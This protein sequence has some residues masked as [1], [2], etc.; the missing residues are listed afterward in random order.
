[1]SR[2][3]Q[4]LTL[5]LGLPC[6][7][8]LHALSFRRVPWGLEKGVAVEAL[9]GV[10]LVRHRVFEVLTFSIGPSA[11]TLWLYLV[12][13]S[14]EFLG[15]GWLSVVLPSILA[16][17]VVVALTTVLAARLFPRSPPYLA[18]LLSAGSVWLFHYGQ[19]GLRAISAPVFL[20]LFTLLLD[21]TNVSREP[22]LSALLAGGVLGLSLYAY[23]SCRVLPLA[24]LAY[25]A[26]DG[27]RAQD[28]R[29]FF[30]GIA[31]TVAGAFLVSI[32][33]FLFF[34]REP[35]EFLER[36]YYVFRGGLGPAL[37]NLAGT[38][39]FPF[40]Y[41]D[42]YKVWLGEGHNFDPTSV[43]LVQ[44][45]VRPI[46]PVTA[47]LFAA[48]LLGLG[49]PRSRTL[50]FLLCTFWMGVLPLGLSGPSLTRF[51][52]LQ[53]VYVLLA[54][55]ALGELHE[56]LRRVRPL[57]VGAALVPGALGAWE[58]V[59]EFGRSATAQSEYDAAASSMSA[60]ARDLLDRGERVMLV[61]RRGRDLVK[62]YTY[63]HIERVFLMEEVLGTVETR[64]EALRRFQPDAVLVERRP[65]FSPL[66][67]R[68]GAPTASRAWYDEFH[69]QKTSGV[70]LPEPG[71]IQRL[72]NEIRR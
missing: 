18:F 32:P 51:L 50:S 11:E 27:R 14:V 42:R 17:C 67:A 70:G 62:L 49:R 29:G 57:L 30:R 2:R 56:R 19:V 10:R 46:D 60:R 9:R 63:R 55:G 61:M 64:G 36:G 53:P 8:V 45:G 12:G 39:A 22:D 47:L 34:M 24:Y 26:W 23:T 16:S 58:Y 54:A 25:A 48:G 66:V 28:R 21:R 40:H 72:W 3:L 20:L 38:L 35:A 44:G 59:T 6:Y 71:N 68:L 65:E 41:P 13:A 43:S 33:N 31:L 4:T 5:A 15:P 7:L 1:V 69:P 52:L 37:V